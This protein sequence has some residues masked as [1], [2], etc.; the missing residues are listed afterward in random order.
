MRG[1]GAREEVL[2][3]IM[4]F[5][6]MLAAPPDRLLGWRALLQAHGVAGSRFGRLMRKAPY[7]FYVNPP[8]LFDSCGP[9]TG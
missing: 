5:P 7:M 4:R 8:Q 2:A 9:N 3:A 6:S 1:Q